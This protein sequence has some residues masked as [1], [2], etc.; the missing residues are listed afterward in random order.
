MP[1]LIGL[2]IGGEYSWGIGFEL[3]GEL[4]I[5]S[6]SICASFE[7]N[8]TITA[9]ITC[10]PGGDCAFN[11]DMSSP[12]FKGTPK[13][14]APSL[15]QLRL[16]PSL[17]AFGFAAVDLGNPFVQQLQ[18]KAIEAKLGPKFSGSFTFD[19]LQID[20]T[21][22]KSDYK[23]Q[24]DLKTGVG[25]GLGEFLKTLGL[26]SIS[27]LE[28]SS[29]TSIGRSPEGGVTADRPFYVQGDP[30][31][32]DVA[33]DSATTSFTIFGP[34]NV[35]E[36]LLVRRTGAVT[37]Q[38]LS[39]Q[40]ASPGQTQF[41]LPFTAPDSFAA[42]ELFAFAVTTIWRYRV[43]KAFA[44]RRAREIAEEEKRQREFEETPEGPPLPEDPEEAMKELKRRQRES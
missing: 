31:Q 9:D 15:N 7:A 18:F 3:S 21:Q 8:G 36:M 29:S 35:S 33:L 39:R 25:A 13:L 22:Y 44:Q 16:Q 5:A 30:G 34:Y 40:A 28:L 27:I 24:G 43:N 6:V 11:G 41:T 20:D 38:V 4:T 1:G 19:A 14:T 17:H 12:I 32:V 26:E 23:L 37:S 10:P 42:T 2:L